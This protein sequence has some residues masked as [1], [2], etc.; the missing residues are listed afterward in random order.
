MSDLAER[1]AQ[2]DIADAET[3]HVALGDR[4]ENRFVVRAEKVETAIAATGLLDG[5]A[6]LV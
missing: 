6:D 3:L 1:C 5:A 2:S 4:V